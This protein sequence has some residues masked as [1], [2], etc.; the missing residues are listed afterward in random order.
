MDDGGL[1]FGYK[2]NMGWMNDTLRYMERD[3]LHRRYHHNEMTFG[4]T[5]AWSENF[6]LPL[7]H[8]EVVHGKR[9][10]LHK[11]P[12][13]MWQ[14][15]ANLRAYLGF[16]WGHPGKKLLFMG[17]EFAQRG[18]W[19]HDRALDWELLSH[20]S[21]SGVQELVRQLNRAYASVPALHELDCEPE[22]FQWLQVDNHDTS[23]FAWLRRDASGESVALVVSNLTPV[24][25]HGYRVGVPGA[26]RYREVI[27]TD[28]A[29]YGGSNI[30]NPAGFEAQP[31]PC[32]HQAWSIQLELPP[33]ATLIIVGR[34]ADTNGSRE[35]GK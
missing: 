12:G 4:I 16:M 34:G 27:N 10:L 26:G 25:R 8:D 1:G 15:F 35:H 23:V 11:M 13:D 33:L 3:P 9:S 30:V 7:S 19:N 6:I 17:S 18:E 28:A 20:H 5:Y 31:E 2:W 21:H 22:G 24:V 32:D 14:Q 29:A